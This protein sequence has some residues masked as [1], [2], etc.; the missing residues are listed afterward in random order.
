V[1]EGIVSEPREPEGPV[2]I[3]VTRKDRNRGPR[4]LAG[5]AYRG[6]STA[7]T[8]RLLFGV[9][10]VVFGLMWTFDNLGWTAAGDV[11]RWWP[12][13]LL[14]YGLARLTGIGLD[15]SPMGGLFFTLLG[16]TLVAAK[17]AH[18]HVGLGI[19][20]PALTILAGISFVRRAMHPEA[21]GDVEPGNRSEFIRMAA[22]MGSA[23]TRAEGTALQRGELTAI[24]GGLELDLRQAQPAT[25]RVV[26]EATAIMG[27]IEIVVPESWAIES[28]LMPVAGGFEDNT[29]RDDGQPVTCTLKLT[30]TAIM[31]GIVAR[32]T[33]SGRHSVRIE[34]KRRRDGRVQEVRISREGIHV[35]REGK[36]VH[37]G[38]EG[39][40]VNPNAPSTPPPSSTPPPPPPVEPR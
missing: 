10:L 6:R 22:I 28:E 14:A 5:F 32:N 40:H 8:T 2:Y 23:Q 4:L 26:M 38:F 16:G 3:G 25:G 36:E 15:R 21:M 37:V 35:T 13:L 34:R 11:V 20:F 30:G 39:V 24:M 18:L 12:A 33:P 7:A 17:L 19:L 29:N 27:G 9:V 1:R 31:G